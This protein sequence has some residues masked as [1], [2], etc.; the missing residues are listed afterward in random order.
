MHCYVFQP[1][2]T[3]RGGSATTSITQ[4][5]SSWL[6]LSVFQDI[7]VWTDVKEVSV[8][9]GTVSFAV[10]TAPNNDDSLFGTMS[11]SATSVTSAGL[12]ISRFLKDTTTNNL[13]R[14]IRWQFTASGT[15]SAWDVTFRMFVAANSPGPQ[16]AGT[17]TK[18]TPV[19]PLAPAST[20]LHLQPV[21]T[22]GL[23]MQVGSAPLSG[24]TAYGNS[25]LQPAVYYSNSSL[26]PAA[27]YGNLA[28]QK[29][30]PGPVKP[31]L[32]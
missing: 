7:V 21:G 13:A 10:Q 26:Q 28:L 22:N 29:R 12:V 14:W 32:L 27:Y 17:T 5:A 15:S 18:L 3:I 11:G 25:P 23:G 8:G 24:A 16:T 1:W 20:P 9:G 30:S 4:T 6:D 2:L 19:A 31:R